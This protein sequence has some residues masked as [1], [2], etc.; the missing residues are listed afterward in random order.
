MPQVCRISIGE[1]RCGLRIAH[2]VP[3]AGGTILVYIALI[4]T[5]R[6]QCIALQVGALPII[7]G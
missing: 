1:K 3:D 7:G 2:V 6:Q 4:D 5:C